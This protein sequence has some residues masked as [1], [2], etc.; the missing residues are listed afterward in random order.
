LSWLDVRHCWTGDCDG[1]RSSNTI[2]VGRAAATDRSRQLNRR[3][4]AAGDRTRVSQMMSVPRSYER[5]ATRESTMGEFSRNST[6]HRRLADNKEIIAA[7]CG[8]D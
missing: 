5:S 4:N 2:V 7:H 1:E 3:A 6:V 8:V